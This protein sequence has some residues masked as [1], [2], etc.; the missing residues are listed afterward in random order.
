K[1]EE[2]RFITAHEGRL[3]SDEV[4]RRVTLRLLDGAIHETNPNTLQKY[5]EERLR[6]YDI[7]LPLE[8]SLTKQVNTPHGDRETGLT[9]L[10]HAAQNEANVNGSPTPYRVE[11]H[12][13]FSI[14]AACLVFSVL[15]VPL[16]IR[17]H[18]GG[19]MGSFVALL[20]IVLFYFFALTVGENIGDYG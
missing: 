3:L 17:A 15:G 1:P 13:K 18:R 19:R 10:R 11:I 8:N 14:P 20:P 7:T 12:M 4:N 6:L 5:R 9:E 16:G 2:Q